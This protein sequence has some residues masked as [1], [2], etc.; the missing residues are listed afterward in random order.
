MTDVFL[1]E[2]GLGINR[3]AEILPLLEWCGTLQ[4]D[5]QVGMRYQEG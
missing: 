5:V 1:C 4:G 3:R 2:V